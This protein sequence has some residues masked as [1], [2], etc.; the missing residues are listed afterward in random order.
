MNLEYMA[1][2]FYNSDYHGTSLSIAHIK[3]H[4]MF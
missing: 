4:Q 3:P 1:I 2:P